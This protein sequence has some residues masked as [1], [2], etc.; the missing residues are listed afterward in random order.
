[1]TIAIDGPAGAGKSTVA[2]KVA[3]ALGYLHVDTGAMYRAVTLYCLQRQID[4]LDEEAVRR[5]VG[6]I[7]V[8]LVPDGGRIIVL[9]NGK[10]VTAAIR[11][12]EIGELVAHVARYYEVRAAMLK[13]Q[14][15]LASGGGVVMDGR[16]IGTV[17]LPSADL[18]VFLTASVSERAHRR[19]QELLARGEKV[20]YQ[21]VY[22]SVK[23]RDRIDSSREI[24]PLKK[25]NDAVEI[26]TTGRSITEVV[27][28]ILALCSA[29][30]GSV[31]ST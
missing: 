13:L 3:E 4:P 30:G 14:R 23:K 5:I 25:A 20:S 18:K 26:D 6:E 16:D 11:K 19:H 1:M 9:L 10:D 24:S 15:R 17:V 28:E 12:P 2:K 7:D 8:R 22:D 21:E 31:C 27:D 29:K